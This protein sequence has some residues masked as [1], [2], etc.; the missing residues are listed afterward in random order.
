M[1]G[2]LHA[3]GVE[4]EDHDMNWLKLEAPQ[5]HNQHSEPQPTSFAAAERDD[6]D[7]SSSSCAGSDNSDSEEEDP[8]HPY[9]VPDTKRWIREG[10]F[11]YA[12]DDLQDSY[13]TAASDVDDAPYV[14]PGEDKGQRAF[15]HPNDL[16]PSS[17]PFLEPYAFRSTP[18]HEQLAVSPLELTRSLPPT[19]PPESRAGPS[20][21]ASARRAHEYVDEMDTD[22][23]ANTSGDD[24]SEDE[25]VP[26]PK[27]RTRQLPSSRASSSSRTKAR[28]THRY[29]YSPYPSSVSTPSSIGESSSQSANG[30][31]P[32]PRNRQI[33]DQS[34]PPRGSWT[35][36][37]PDAY[38][39][40]H[41]DHFQKNKRS[42]DME[43]HIRSHFRTATS[44]KW[45]CCG[46]P[47]EEAEIYAVSREANPW[48]FN[49][50][51]FVGGCHK[52]F[53]RMDALKRHWKNKNNTCAGD[54]M[55]ARSDYE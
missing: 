32:G 6:D 23:E 12:A 33:F 43:R 24:A 21:R 29:S 45:V 35:K 52:D 8:Y 53:S 15:I 13:L 9:N 47:V 5:F 44:E 34:P 7:G 42:P 26:S 25:Y 10:D 36:T 49:G 39:C 31:Q 55:Y 19:P 41:C 37:G 1:A 20:R 11:V 46:I 38:R 17:S 30:R 3:R 50:Q 48:E 2:A 18:S 51:T 22:D 27:V 54:I 14:P 28:S 40:P 16:A 4:H